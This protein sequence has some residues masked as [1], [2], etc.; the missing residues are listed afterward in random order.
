MTPS[1]SSALAA[2][3]G[4]QTPRIANYPPYTSSSA[5]EAIELAESAGL[6]LDDWQRYVLQ[7]GLGEHRGRW[8]ATRVGCWVPR[9]NGKGGIIEA[10]ELFWLFLAGER[11]ILHSAHEYKTA[12]EGFLRLKELIERCP[13]LDA[14]VDRYWQANG[15]QGISLTRK[16]GG[17]R[18]RFVARSRTSGRGFSGDKNILDEGQELTEQQIAALMPTI[19]ARPDPQIWFFG[20]PPELPDAW[21]YRLKADG[22]AGR[23]RLAW[24]DWG[25]DL[26]LDNPV[27]RL[28][29]DDRDLW[30]ATNPAMGIRILEATVE[31]ER[32]ESGLG[33]KFAHERLGVWLPAAVPGAVLDPAMWSKMLDRESRRG[34]GEPVMLAFDVTPLRDHATIGLYA[35]RDDGREHMQLID[36]RP[37][38]DWLVPRL[39]ELREVLDPIG[40]AYDQKNGAHTFLPDLRE[41]GIER[42]QD[43]E[44]WDQD[45]KRGDL[46]ELDTAAAVDAVGQFI[47]G[48][49]APPIEIDGTAVPRMAHLGQEPLDVAVR[50]AV[51]R[52]IGD[53]GQIG[54]GRRASEVDIGP[55]CAVTEAR[56]GYRLWVDVVLGDYDVADSVF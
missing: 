37:G 26:D 5:A 21:A 48:F 51:A 42:P 30:Y 1:T 43:R 28:R 7:H 31:D 49:R 8:A 45:P 56:Y 34:D 47:D 32:A 52:P 23:P 18:L 14:K 12:Q 22:E 4:A 50:G 24:F 33:E 38:T 13:D 20:T 9:Q 53:A 39:V 46:L 16:A 17:A 3:R 27:D 25:A 55:L 40:I 36:H 41:H 54:W 35:L 19:S 10:L 44:E 29:L 6:R 11:L 15:E 2:R